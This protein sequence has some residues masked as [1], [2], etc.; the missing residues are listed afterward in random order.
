MNGIV[1]KIVDGIQK[2]EKITG[3]KPFAILVS[4]TTYGQ[5][6]A[7]NNLN[8]HCCNYNTTRAMDYILNVPIEVSNEIDCPTFFANEHFYR[9]YC[10]ERINEKINKWMENK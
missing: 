7:D 6:K 3:K 9:E 1:E 2:Y 4:P 8:K 10:K 5:I